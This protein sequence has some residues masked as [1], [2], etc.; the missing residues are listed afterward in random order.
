[1]VRNYKLE[2]YVTFETNVN[3]NRLFS[4][5]ARAKVYFHPMVGEHFGMSVV[6]AM[7]AG[8]IPVVPNIGGQTEFVPLKYHLSTI[9]EAAEKVSSAFYDSDL[10]SSNKQF[11]KQI[12]SIQLYK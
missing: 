7:A 1:M 2:D 4:I 6:E 12:F 10:E 11:R 5:M 8:L 9:E 3:L